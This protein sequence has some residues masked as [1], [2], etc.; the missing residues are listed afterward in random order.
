MEVEGEG[1]LGELTV[2]AQQHRPRFDAMFLRNLQHALL[3]HHR[4][5]RAAKRAVG[6][7]VDALGA[8]IVDDLLLGQ[9]G[10]VLDLVDGGS[11]GGVWE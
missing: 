5:P 3:L 11:D 9:V 8:A 2:I 4:A 7:D 6:R 10:V 1:D